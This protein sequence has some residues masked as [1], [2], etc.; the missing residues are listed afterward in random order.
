TPITSVDAIDVGGSVHLTLIR[1]GF[2]RCGYLAVVI[3]GPAPDVSSVL[4]TGSDRNTRLVDA[5]TFNYALAN[6]D[7]QR[8][9]FHFAVALDRALVRIGKLSV[10]LKRECVIVVAIVRITLPIA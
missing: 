7:A 9:F 1:V 3:S 5:V 2:K 6:L 8:M 4:D 10:P